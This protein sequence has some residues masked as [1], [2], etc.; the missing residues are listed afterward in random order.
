[1]RLVINLRDEAHRFALDYHRKIRDR[2]MISSFFDSVRGIGEKKKN[3]LYENFNSVEELKMQSLE[4][5]LKLKGISYTDAKNI[6][7][8]LHK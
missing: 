7:D 1:M 2:Q 4:N 3:I 8:A 6:Y 5:I